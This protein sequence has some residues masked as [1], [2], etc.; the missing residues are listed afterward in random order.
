MYV[1][2]RMSTEV[3]TVTPKTLLLD[4]NELMEEKGLWML[5]VVH[6]EKLVGY[7]HREDVR[8]ALP[9][10]ATL[11]SKHELPSIL[12]KVTIEE[13]IRKDTVTVTP[14]TDIETAAELMSIND[15]HGMAVVDSSGKLVGYIS[16]RIMLD[17]LVDEMG[18]HRGGKRFTIAFKDRKG[19]MA[20]VSNI[21]SDMGINFVS[22]ASFFHGDT[23]ILVFRV[24]TE[25]LSPIVEVLKERKYNIVG[26]DYFANAWKA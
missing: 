9:S 1:G 5:C 10:R 3:V 14:E 19:V 16:H 7:L 23:C 25:D 4:A 11:L 12:S 26:P 13:L 21:I 8:A 24:Q 18:L 17:V 20:E 15:L 6:K 22:A 2:L